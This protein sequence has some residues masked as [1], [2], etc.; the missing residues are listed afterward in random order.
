LIVFVGRSERLRR[1]G[2]CQAHISSF[3]EELGSFLDDVAQISEI[4][5]PSTIGCKSPFGNP[6]VSFGSLQQVLSNVN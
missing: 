1:T 3:D 2:Q 5:I 4:Q 6:H